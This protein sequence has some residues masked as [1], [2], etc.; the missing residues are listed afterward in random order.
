MTAVKMNN[1]SNNFTNSSLD[2]STTNNNDNNNFTDSTFVFSQIKQNIVNVL[3]FKKPLTILKETVYNRNF[4]QSEITS[5]E[6]WYIYISSLLNNQAQLNIKQDLLLELTEFIVPYYKVDKSQY[7]KVY[8]EKFTKIFTLTLNY[9][10]KLNINLFEDILEETSNIVNS[11]SFDLENK[12][13]STNQI[14][15]KKYKYASMKELILIMIEAY[16]DACFQYASC[17]DFE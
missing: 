10:Y 1:D 15:L 2:L 17:L 7:K 16:S 3:F 6:E 5:Y 13:T 11:N 12:S 8:L 4:V 14:N 9:N